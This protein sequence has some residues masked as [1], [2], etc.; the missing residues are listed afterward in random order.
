MHE[1]PIVSLFAP[2]RA[3]QGST[4][5]VQMRWPR[6]AGKGPITF[7]FSRPF[8][9]IEVHNAELVAHEPG[10]S[11]VTLTA[12]EPGY[13]GLLVQS[14]RAVE[15]AAQMSI[16]V[17]GAL[18][19][20]EFVDER[21]VTLFR[22]VITARQV[23][24]VTNVGGEPSRPTMRAPVNLANLGEGTAIVLLNVEHIDSEES[25]LSA[26]AWTAKDAFLKD[27]S[28][29]LPGLCEALPKHA[30]LIQQ[31]IHHLQTPPDLDNPKV[32]ADI[33]AFLDQ[34]HTAVLTD[35]ELNQSLQEV[36]AWAVTR[37][38]TLAELVVEFVN[39]LFAG[40][41]EGVILANALDRL[42]LPKGASRF[43][44]SVDVLDLNRADYPRLEL[45]VIEFTA[46][47]ACEVPVHQLLRY[48]PPAAPQGG[49][50]ID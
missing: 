15:A 11:C 41:T 19:G 8:E 3:L 42:P 18:D 49:I 16:S 5:P 43:R 33:D 32:V 7:A 21:R 31:F 34:F 20:R 1:P 50:P 4:I 17:R 27:L 13:L 9:L 37:N 12:E 39:Y 44:L 30:D 23:A 6:E 38:F 35:S 2:P 22:P 29:R 40:G 46:D 26:P 36:I 45:G 28:S 14:D 24:A 47:A 48:V 25:A 10:S